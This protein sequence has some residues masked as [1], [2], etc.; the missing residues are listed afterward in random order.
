MALRGWR[1]L[2]RTRPATTSLVFVALLLALALNF[3]GVA[4]YHAY[5]GRQ[6]LIQ[7]AREALLP[8]LS[9]HLFS[10]VLTMV[11]V[12]VAVET[13]TVGITV[14]GVMIILFQYLVGELLKSE[15]RGEEL[16]RVATTDELTGLANRER[17][18]AELEDQRSRRR[19]SRRERSRS[20]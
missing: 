14:V 8:L 18:R 12:Y 19:A 7:M 6:S 10:G 13:G 11:S 1:T 9:A 15:A 3:L 5:L 4:G 17:F 2:A 20:C 16:H